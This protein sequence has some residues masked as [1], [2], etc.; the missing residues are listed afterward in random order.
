MGEADFK[1]IMLLRNQL[2]IAAEIFVKEENLSPLLIPKITKDKVEQIK[3]ADNVVHVV[4]WA[5]RL[6]CV[7]LVRYNVDWSESSHAQVRLFARKNEEETFQQF[8]YM[9]YKLEEFPSFWCNEVC[10]G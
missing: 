3:K 4:D 6:I 8:F 10:Q 1:K 2:V 7:T 5:N 9:I